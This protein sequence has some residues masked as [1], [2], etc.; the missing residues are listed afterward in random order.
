MISTTFASDLLKLLLNATAIT[1]LATN[2]TT[3]P[4]ANLYLSLHTADPG[5]AGAQNTSEATYTGYA[6][7]AIARTTTGWTISGVVAS[8]TST[9]EFGEMTGGT[10]QTVTYACLGTDVSGAGKVLFRFALTPSIAMAV[11]VTPRLRNTTTLTA[12]TS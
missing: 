7:I 10:T 11:G 4:L 5:A 12:V 2:A 6:R 8:P 9:M 3:S 1:G